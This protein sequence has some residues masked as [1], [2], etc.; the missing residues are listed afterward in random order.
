MTLKPVGIPLP[1][2]L[3]HSAKKNINVNT[4]LL[5]KKKIYKLG[6]LDFSRDIDLC[7]CVYLCVSGDRTDL[8]GS[9]V[10]L[11]LYAFL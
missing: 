4:T 6:T 10:T 5:L 3:S 2:F 1:Y 9:I 7:L 11:S 8:Q